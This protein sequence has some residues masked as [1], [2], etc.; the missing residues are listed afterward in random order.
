MW[1]VDCEETDLSSRTGGQVSIG[2]RTD[3]VEHKGI[4]TCARIEMSKD[5]DTAE[6]KVKWFLKVHK[7][8]KLL[9]EAYFQFSFLFTF[10]F[11][12]FFDFHPPPPPEMRV[13]LRN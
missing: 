8:Y 2:K 4:G 9:W 7:I 6:Q 5:A 13:T 3:K 1:F 11:Y 10:T 12:K